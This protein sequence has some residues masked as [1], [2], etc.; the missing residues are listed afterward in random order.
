[1]TETSR[2]RRAA[3]EKSPAAAAFRAA[4]TIDPRSSAPF[5]ELLAQ[6]LYAFSRRMMHSRNG[7]AGSPIAVWCESRT[8]RS[9]DDAAGLPGEQGSVISASLR[10]GDRLRARE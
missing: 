3:V 7:R 4:S 10:V 9:S 8:A 6:R 5:I 2:N 1:M